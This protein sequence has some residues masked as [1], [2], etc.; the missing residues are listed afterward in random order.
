MLCFRWTLVSDIS[1]HLATIGYKLLAVMLNKIG[2]IDTVCTL[3]VLVRHVFVYRPAEGAGA[4]GWAVNELVS[5]LKFPTN[6]DVRPTN[7]CR[8]NRVRS[9]FTLIE[10]TMVVLIIGI[11]AAVAVPRYSNA[12][13]R[14]NA[15][16]AARR[17]KTDLEFLRHQARRAGS[18]KSIVF[19]TSTHSY[20]LAGVSDLNHP[21]Q[22]YEVQLTRL[23]Y[24][25][26]LHQ[27]NCGGDTQLSI[28]G[29]GK[30][31]SGATIVVVSGGYSRTVSLE[32][33]AGAATIQ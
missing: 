27:V 19:N 3:D 26:T 14:Y 18:S 33:N 22:D 16:A 23:P 7:T 2:T 25:A 30:P 1:V 21:G 13:A 24:N 5:V 10:L 11:L 29:F 32:P 28:D 17:I 15:D 4:F 6:E 31:D 8:H 12:T 9:A 20:K